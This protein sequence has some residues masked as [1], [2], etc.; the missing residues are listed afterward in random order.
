MDLCPEKKALS[1]EDLEN[2]YGRTW[3]WTAFDVNTRLIICF[4]VGDR[5][6]EACRN[7][8]KDLSSRITNK[9]LFVSDELPHYETV[10]LETYHTTETFEKTGKP[11]RPKNPVIK[12][13]EQ[14]DYAV[15]HKTRENGTV[16]KVETRIIFGNEQR[17]KERLE[18]SVSNKI[19]TSY[20]ERSN[21]TLRLNDAHLQR[22][23]YKFSKDMDFLKAKL[24]IIIL[25]YNFIKPHST[26]SKNPDKTYTPRTPALKAGIVDYI[27]TTKFAFELPELNITIN[28]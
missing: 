5:T 19:N 2:Q 4:L 17:I 7:F 28:L 11:G 24:A 1:E 13:D 15:V 10:I 21:G 27:W 18:N 3:I 26:L 6:L 9:P 8:F 12:V 22:K 14:I 23:T 20:I 16:K 25:F